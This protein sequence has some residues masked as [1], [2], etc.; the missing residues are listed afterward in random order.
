MSD[1]VDQLTEH[2]QQ[3]LL[4]ALHKVGEAADAL[5]LRGMGGLSEAVDDIHDRLSVFLVNN[6][7]DEGDR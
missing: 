3:L 2:E 6:G 7:Y 4:D 1:S 5:D